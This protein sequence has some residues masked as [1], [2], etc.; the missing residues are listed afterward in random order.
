[1]LICVALFPAALRSAESKDC[2]LKQYASLDLPALPNG[3][4][5]VPVTIQGT[6]VFMLLNTISPFSSIT[7]IAA[8]R[9]GLQIHQMPFGV[10]VSSGAKKIENV[11]AAKGLSLGYAHFN[12][13]ELLIIPNDFIGPSPDDMQV[14]G[15]LGMDVF[16]KI[17]V[18]LDLSK[19]KMKLFSQDRCKGHT[20]VYWSKAYDSVPIRLGRLGEIYFPMELGGKKIE[21]TLAT[22]NASTSLYSDASRKLFNFDS[23]SPDVQNETDAAGRTTAYYRVMNLTGEGLQVINAR[24]KIIDPSLNTPCQFAVRSGVAAYEGC[25]GVHPLELGRNVLTKLRIYIATKEKV[26]YFTSADASD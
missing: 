25:F 16:T 9:L 3:H 2:Q 5:I 6:D 20:V 12:N 15:F 22:G 10:N 26:L 14:V 1:M 7:E 13:A 23:H 17:D 19:R 21:T 24:I 4:L 11:A 18:E 8:N